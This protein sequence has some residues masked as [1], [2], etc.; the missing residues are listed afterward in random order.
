MLFMNSD[1]F[2][3]PSSPYKSKNHLP[4]LLF[5][6]QFFK[7]SLADARL[8]IDKWGLINCLLSLKSSSETHFFLLLFYSQL[9]MAEQANL[10]PLGCALFLPEFILTSWPFFDTH[11]ACSV[12]HVSSLHAHWLQINTWQ[13]TGCFSQY[14]Y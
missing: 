6:L 12:V 7:W 4:I 14:S 9:H 3:I 10:L 11:P 5:S 13:R 2:Y 1:L 8:L